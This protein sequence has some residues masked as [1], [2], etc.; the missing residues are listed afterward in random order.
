MKLRTTLLDLP[1]EL[2]A[3]CLLKT[4]FYSGLITSLREFAKLQMVCTRFRDIVRHHCPD[5][6]THICLPHGCFSKD[7]L[8]S[9]ATFLSTVIDPRSI[10]LF[11]AQPEGWEM[12]RVC[13]ILDAASNSLRKMILK[14]CLSCRPH[15]PRLSRTL[16]NLSALT[17]LCITNT[18]EF[19]YIIPTIPTLQYLSIQLPGNMPVHSIEGFVARQP[20]LEELYMH[21]NGH[22]P[23]LEGGCRSICTFL[24]K[25][26]LLRTLELRLGH[27]DLDQLL[28]CPVPLPV[29][30]LGVE[31][32]N[33]VRSCECLR[34]FHFLQDI[35]VK[36]IRVP[37]SYQ[38]PD[39]FPVMPHLRQADFFN[40]YLGASAEAIS[41]WTG[42]TE[43]TLTNCRPRQLD[44]L[45]A[46]TSMHEL[47]VEDNHFIHSLRGLGGLH[48]LQT[49]VC[50]G[51]LLDAAA[52]AGVTQLKALK[53][54]ACSQFVKNVPWER[55]APSLEMLVVCP[56]AL[57][58][59]SAAS[60]PRLTK[61][62]LEGMVKSAD[63]EVSVGT[64]LNNL[65][66]E[67]M[68]RVEWNGSF[69]VKSSFGGFG[70]L[71]RILHFAHTY[72]IACRLLLYRNPRVHD[73]YL[74][75]L[76]NASV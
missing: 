39:P 60:F 21:A 27:V 49:F 28:D 33:P 13:D 43:L 64:F 63:D 22:D 18:L 10:T 15:R 56:Q 31:V 55:L 74:Y 52:L 59:S 30:H 9:F 35:R 5:A 47:V 72:P 6:W 53:L 45:S 37:L 8:R 50:S 24:L 58:G 2:L 41:A 67:T 75:D 1:D 69:L 48:C 20:A 65:N 46:M 44:G 71:Q 32:W 4:T 51:P 62:K 29:V 61:V 73:H 42:L 40:V 26:P 19:V 23:A 16:S 3:Q 17:H 70:E 14:T 54:V 38:E 7:G 68:E 76:K 66:P 25:L 11:E 57:R 36:S 12:D 34:A